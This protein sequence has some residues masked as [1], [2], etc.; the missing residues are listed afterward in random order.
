M[1]YVN[2]YFTEVPSDRK[3]DFNPIIQMQLEYGSFFRTFVG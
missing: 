3:F 1:V 2:L